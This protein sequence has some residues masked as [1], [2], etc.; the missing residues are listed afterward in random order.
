VEERSSRGLRP[1]A[2][3]P[4]TETQTVPS[5][6]QHGAPITGGVVSQRVRGQH[7]T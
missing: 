6:V 5:I 3:L 2:T 7:K 4:L 1:R